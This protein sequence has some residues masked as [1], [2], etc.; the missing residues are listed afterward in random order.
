MKKVIALLTCALCSGSTSASTD[1]A[2][3]RCWSTRCR[4]ACRTCRCAGCASCVAR[5]RRG[6]TGIWISTV[7][8]KV[9]NEKCEREQTKCGEIRR[10]I[11]S[12]Y[13]RQIL[14]DLAILVAP[15]VCVSV[16]ILCMCV[17]VCCTADNA[18]L[19]ID[20]DAFVINLCEIH[21][22]CHI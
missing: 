17:C 14:S 9:C 22:L 19:W 7:R 16:Y 15:S 3:R 12:I 4:G 8:A 1:S 2:S 10:T 21:L 13:G 6:R 20:A 18:S 11:R 5:W